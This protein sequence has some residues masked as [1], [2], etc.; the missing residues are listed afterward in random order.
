VGDRT[1]ILLVDPAP[2]DAL[3]PSL[4]STFEV[5]AVAS[6][7]QAIRALRLLQPTLVITELALQDGD[8]VAVCRSSKAIGNGE[9]SVL[10]TTADVERVP[11]ALSAGCDGVL[12]KPFAP[13]LLH[14]R[15]GRLL[16]QKEAAARQQ[17]A[18]SQLDGATR[19]GR[20]RGTRAGTNAIVPGE[21]CPACGRG[22]V[23]SFDVVNIRQEWYACLPCRK[24]WVGPTPRVP[25][26]RQSLP[27]RQASTL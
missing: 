26:A 6:E 21:R 10:V 12:L 11:E 9:T 2:G 14:A 24:V 5:S 17:A 19:Y 13:N 7:D 18:W 1:S 15:I 16:R 8:G 20:L 22:E 4:R 25:V 27:P 23:V 3:L